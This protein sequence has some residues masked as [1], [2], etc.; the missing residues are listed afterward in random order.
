MRS[1]IVHGGAW[2][3]PDDEVAAHLSGIRAAVEK[4]MI[5]LRSGAPA[6]DV[7]VETIALLEDDPTFDAGHGSVLNQDGEIEMDASVMDGFTMRAGACMCVTDVANPVRLAKA[8][9][10]DGRAVMLAGDG[11]SR[12]ARS[13]GIPA[14]RAEDLLVPRETARREYLERLESYKT[15]QPFDGSLGKPH[16]DPHP[17]IDRPL[18]T[19][20]AVCCDARGRLAA[21]T[22][23][24]GAPYTLPGRVG[25]SPILGAGTWAENGVGAA[26][27]T[28]WGEAILRDLLAFRAVQ[29]ID[30]VTIEWRRPRGARRGESPSSR[31]DRPADVPS[32]APVRV[33]Y[34]PIP[35]GVGDTAAAR[36]ARM[37]IRAFERRV[38]GVG[39]VILIGPD[40]DPGFAFN[41]PRMA[42]GFWIEGMGEPIVECDP[43]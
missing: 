4:G 1:I 7:V 31:P 17:A 6:L 33:T 28:G 23:T 9:L 27:A 11:A 37:A 22:S 38:Y 21:A 12:F 29:E 40:G 16:P 13:V 19:V 2:Q 43:A 41:T 10:D 25:D 36:A 15:R 5:L 3:I 32:I 42:R 24:G 34:G 35:R 20:G 39:G 30:T 26:S 14:C 18:G 8:I